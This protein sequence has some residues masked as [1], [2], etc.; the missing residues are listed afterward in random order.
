V[1]FNPAST[2]VLSSPLPFLPCSKGQAQERI[3]MS[4]HLFGSGVL[5][6][7]LWP[8]LSAAADT[9]DAAFF[10]SKIRP[11]LVERCYQCHAA[12]TK[13]R[14]GLRLDAKDM[15]LKG[16]RPRPRLG[17]RQARG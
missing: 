6:L 5:A 15:V 13:Q 1:S 4:R 16:G 10:E 11:V 14:G 17:G 8:G 12:S 2:A 9:V 3:K 7:A